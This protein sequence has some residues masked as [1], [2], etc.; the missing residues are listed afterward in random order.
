M[1]AKLLVLLI[2]LFIGITAKSQNYYYLS[3]QNSSYERLEG[4]TIIASTEFGD[5]APIGFTFSYFNAG[6]DTVFLGFPGSIDL[7]GGW[8]HGI[9]G[10]FEPHPNKTSYMAYKTVGEAPNR[11]FK[12]EWTNWGT[13]SDSAEYDSVN[14]QIW[15]LE[16]SNAVEFHF[17]PTYISQSAING[18]LFVDNHSGPNVGIFN[19]FM[20][21]Y[22]ITGSANNPQLTISKMMTFMDDVPQ[23][24]LV[25][26]FTAVK[27][28]KVA[29]V[30][31]YGGAIIQGGANYRL[32]WNKPVQD[33]TLEYS[34]DHGVNWNQIAS[35]L[36]DSFYTWT[37]P[38]ASS[39][40]LVFR[41]KDELGTVLCE[42]E[43]ANQILGQA[44]NAVIETW[45]E[46][47][48]V[49]PNPA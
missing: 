38:F 45:M 36:N 11:I 12:M 18:G 49:Y 16:N 13:K 39:N 35:N 17:G 2:A 37:A 31:G 33:V 3:F 43:Y 46:M 1:K 24:G 29:F 15:F 27:D 41:L 26:R 32:V 21:H 7:D 40:A 23:E 19:F 30:Q 22:G 14:Y 44:P 34:A 9:E 42:S 6:V 48:Q 47:I 25:Y 8:I 5:Y 28:D 20:E 10:N 4:A